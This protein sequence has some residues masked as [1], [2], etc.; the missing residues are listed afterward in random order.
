MR[1]MEFTTMNKPLKKYKKGRN[2]A[3]YIKTMLQ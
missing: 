3:R 2:Q 1:T